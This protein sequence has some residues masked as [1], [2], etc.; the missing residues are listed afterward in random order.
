MCVKISRTPLLC[1]AGKN[2]IAVNV[3]DYARKNFPELEI[4]AVMNSNESFKNSWQR[5][6]GLYCQDNGIKI[7][8]LEDVYG[9]EELIFLSVE[10][11]KIIIP[12][13]FKSPNLYNIHFSLLP[14][15]KGC[16]T[17]IIPILHGERKS[18][19]TLHRIRRGIDTGEIIAQREVEISYDDNSLKLYC[20]LIKAGSELACEYLGRLIAHD[21][22]E[23]PQSFINSEY[24]S[25]RDIDYG[26]L[27]L[28]INRTAEQI[29]N[30]IRAFAFRPYQLLTFRNCGLVGSRITHNV[31]HEKPGTILEETETHFLVSTIDYDIYIYK[32]VLSEIIAALRS[33]DD[34]RAK[35]LCEFAP[36]INDADMNGFSPAS[37]AKSEN[38]SEMINFFDE[39]ILDWAQKIQYN[40]LSALS[41]QLSALKSTLSLNSR[42]KFNK[43]IYAFS[44]KRYSRLFGRA[45]FIA[46]CQECI[47]AS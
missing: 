17:S 46:R 44:C 16:N 3:L 5:S 39:I 11:D 8:S 15:Y 7:V 31:S 24:F 38:N 32:D 2:D 4:V 33:H 10:F 36:I 34:E 25:R 14:K 43:K 19:V 40:Q 45:Y 29:H 9:I 35:S 37:I 30:Q 20:K 42:K 26:N 18:G 21:F 12:A 23:I 13:K 22:T 6:A 28:D 1:I 27:K 47:C 41:S